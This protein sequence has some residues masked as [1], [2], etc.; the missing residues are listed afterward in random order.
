MN[1]VDTLHQKID[2]TEHMV[3]GG[4]GQVR[5]IHI[6]ELILDNQLQIMRALTAILLGRFEPYDD[7]QE[8]S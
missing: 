2:E 5:D 6:N 1:V 3:V 7:S 8:I 4:L